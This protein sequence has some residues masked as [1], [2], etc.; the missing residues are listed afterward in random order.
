M[1]V[2]AAVLL[3][4][5]CALA[6]CGETRF[7]PQPSTAAG[8]SPFGAT[9]GL[10]AAVPRTW[11]DS[12]SGPAPVPEPRRIA[13]PYAE[14][15]GHLGAGRET[16]ALLFAGNEGQV[17][18]VAL[19]QGGEGEVEARDGLATLVAADEAAT[20][21]DAALRVLI[22]DDGLAAPR[23]AELAA[24]GA[25]ASEL[26]F[27]L[28]AD[29]DYVVQLRPPGTRLYRLS[30][31]LHAPLPFPVRGFDHLAIR[32][33][34]GASRDSGNRRHE[35]VDIFAPRR[36][37][38]LAVADGRV[39]VHAEGRGGIAVVLSIAGISYYY[40]HLERTAVGE[41]QRVR[42]GDVLGYVGSTGNAGGSAPHLHFGVYQFGKGAV[43]PLPLL[44]A[45]RFAEGAH[46]PLMAAASTDAAMDAAG[47][48]A[49][50]SGTG[51]R[52]GASAGAGTPSAVAALAAVVSGG[53]GAS[54]SASLAATGVY[55]GAGSAAAM[56]DSWTV[57][58]E[59]RSALLTLSGAA[60]LCT[61]GT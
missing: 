24:L 41:G 27:R 51:S 54:A 4:A 10:V 12:S 34:F 56:A 16:A 44:E 30:L 47:A 8:F 46:E 28:P 29:G 15:G 25:G 1:P 60:V 32:S 39:S 53:C 55:E 43:D 45:R 7:A 19:E 58:A 23:Y 31:E 18:K 52:I 20:A 6:G 14:I 42:I 5:A 11:A 22:V 3:G 9:A 40:A 37:P 2:A 35:G 57:L 26:Y 17:L 33:Y 50:G 59:P 13:L 61:D 48:P 21:R 36:T 38:V 49:S